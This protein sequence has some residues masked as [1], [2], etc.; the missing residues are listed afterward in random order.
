MRD[1][2]PLLLV[3]HEQAE[4]AEVDVLRQQPVGADDHVHLAGGQVGER[5]LLLG[6]RAEAADHVDRHREGRE[7][8]AERPQVLEG[9]HG[10]GREEGDLLAVHD[11][12]E[13][14]AHR[15]LGLAVADIAAQQPVHGRR[16]L[17]VAA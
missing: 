7:A 15:H 3:H 12:L 9:E 14:R 1:A 2:E 11:R 13:R 16:R 4:V 8:L 5:L 6:A 10:R 17:H